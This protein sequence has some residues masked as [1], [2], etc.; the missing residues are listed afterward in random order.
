M[1]NFTYCNPVR[2]LFGRGMIGELATLV[3]AGSRV[4]LAYGGGSIKHNGVFEQVSDALQKFTVVEFGGIEPNPRYESCMKAVEI[5]RREG[6]DFIL[7]VGGGSVLDG[8]KFIAAAA[9]FEGDDPWRIVKEALPVNDAVPLGCVLTLPATGSEMN[10]FSVVSRISSGEKLAFSAAACYPRF[11]ILDPATT[12]SLPQRQVRNG[13]V[14]TIAHVMEQYVCKAPETPLQA[15]QAEAILTTVIEQAPRVFAEPQ[16]YDVRANLMWCATAALNCHLGCG[17]EAQDWATHIIGHELTALYGLDHGQTLAV[18]M[19]AVHAF[20]IERKRERLAQCAE[21]VWGVREGTAAEKAQ[22][23]VER[24]KEF[25]GSIGV[26]VSLS[27]YGIDADAAAGKVAERLAL[28]RGG[29][30]E[31]GDLAAAEVAAIVRMAR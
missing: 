1:V 17:V 26:P 11:S 27:A 16:N 31:Y 6:V 5:V 25:F 29:I 2:I 28:R 4:M 20:Q 7:A 14:D 18:I 19:P 10:C 12:F 24:L 23:A 15:R 8:V 13:I 22:R 30:G 9:R 3:P 21:R